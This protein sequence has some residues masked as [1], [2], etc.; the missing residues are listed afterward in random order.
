[1]AMPF[2]QGLAKIAAANAVAP[3]HELHIAGEVQ[4]K[5][6][7]T[8]EDLAVRPRVCCCADYKVF[9]SCMH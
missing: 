1:M 6:I 4:A 8:D 5:T 2:A 9:N 3:A 7:E